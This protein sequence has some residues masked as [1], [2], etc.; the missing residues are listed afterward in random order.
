MRHGRPG[1]SIWLIFSHWT[2]VSFKHKALARNLPDAK[3]ARHTRLHPRAWCTMAERGPAG[4]AGRAA[5]SRSSPRAP[6]NTPGPSVAPRR[7]GGGAV[8]RLGAVCA[9]AGRR[10]RSLRIHPHQPR[11]RHSAV[12]A[13]AQTRASPSSPPLRPGPTRVFNRG[14]GARGR[15]SGGRCPP[16]RPAGP[17]AAH[18]LV[19]RNG[20][21]GRAGRTRAPVRL[22]WP[23]AG[24]VNTASS[25]AGR[26]C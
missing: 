11:R 18:R 22:A 4:P 25:R 2:H 14:A 8:G 9:R 21:V 7:G 10:E 13:P 23:R 16:T 17:A 20:R 24:R 5:R 3:P 15:H 1:V 19:G 12:T 6:Q 26:V